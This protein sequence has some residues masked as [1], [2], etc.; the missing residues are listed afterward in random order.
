MAMRNNRN[1]TLYILI[2]LIVTAILLSLLN[3]L[4]LKHQSSNQV[5]TNIDSNSS[6]SSLQYD[7]QSQG[8]DPLE[9][10]KLAFTGKDID[11]YNINQPIQA[12]KVEFKITEFAKYQYISPIGNAQGDY[13]S[14]SF[15]IKNL[16]TTQL[17]IIPQY[18][19]SLDD[20]S[21]TGGV[22]LDSNLVQSFVSRPIV[23]L[24]DFSTIRLDPQQSYEG[25]LPFICD[26]SPS[27]IFAVNINQFTIQGE[28][29]NLPKNPIN[30]TEFKPIKIK[31]KLN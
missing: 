17:K 22:L 30:P 26:N 15:G 29:N 21:P 6:I 24:I 10:I 9:L 31:L 7:L 11:N 19:F 3:L 20:G 18:D 12:N 28:L 27:Y 16:D 2:I 5:G 23:P 13:C 8:K 4:N 14:I 25:S 1:S